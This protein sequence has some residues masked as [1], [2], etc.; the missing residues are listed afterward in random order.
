ME[1]SAIKDLLYG[2][3]SE[4]MKN[5]RY[6]YQSSVGKSYCKWTDDG[7][8]ALKEFVTEI[9]HFITEADKKELDVRAK[10]IVMD[11]LK[12]KE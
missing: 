5:H 4:L 2:G 1:K 12:G 9:T 10:Q 7:E 8:Q 6:Y 11:S 3:V